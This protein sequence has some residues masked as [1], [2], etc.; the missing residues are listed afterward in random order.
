MIHAGDLQK[1]WFYLKKNG[2]RNTFFA[3]LER[4]QERKRTSYQFCGLS[5]GEYEKQKHTQFEN[6]DLF[7][8]LVPMY[9]TASDYAKEMIQSVLAQSYPHFE[10]I[11]A[12]ASESEKVRD[13]VSSF[14]D[15]RIVYVRLERNEGISGNSN[16]ALQYA[17]GN[18]TALLDHDDLLTP[19]ALY[20]MEEK[21][22]EG[23]EENRSYA[24]LYSDE[25]KCDTDGTRMYDPN[26]KPEFNLDLLLT[27]NYICHFLVLKT[28]LIKRA[29]FRK[30]YD[31]AQDFD[32]ILHA[33]SLKNEQDEIAHIGQVLYHWR[34]HPAS[35]ASNPQSKLY[36]YAAGKNAIAEYL[37][38]QNISAEVKN[39]A[40]NGF[41]RV[42]YGK[43]ETAA[44]IFEARK[45]IGAVAGPVVNH[46]KIKSG[47]LTK[48]TEC[49]YEGLNMHFS[50]YL[51]RASLQQEVRAADL[52]NLAILPQLRTLMI[53][54][55]QETEK[56]L[57]RAEGMIS[58]QQSRLSA[59]DEQEIRT[60]SIKICNEITKHGYRIFYDPNFCR[61]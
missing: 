44:E 2:I 5:A 29:G 10:L 13:I 51:H 50:G 57:K 20:R 18:Y 23:R 1:S 11:L 45:D 12:D 33:F 53:Q 54:E 19:D 26:L 42:I 49:P 6:P 60:I 16:A 47:I 14:S 61:K 58:G 46:G 40:H 56:L 37:K 7:S 34:C 25:D 4:L 32:L 48:D 36:A 22:C 31:G 15:E 17:K 24:I 8:I 59:R 21:I 38:T 41:Y 55:N 39:T 28:D 3:T 52:R 30:E 35:T 43:N 27:N 9:E